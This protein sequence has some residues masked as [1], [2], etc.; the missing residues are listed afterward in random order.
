MPC[1]IYLL[2]DIAY[3]YMLW[4]H[5][6]MMAMN[7]TFVCF[8]TCVL[9][10]RDKNYSQNKKEIVEDIYL[11]RV[12][13]NVTMNYASIHATVNTKVRCGGMY[14]DILW[15]RKIGP[16]EIQIISTFCIILLPGSKLFYYNCIFLLFITAVS[17]YNPILINILFRFLLLKT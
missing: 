9:C 1:F 2:D 12:W 6:M 8:V 3:T 5:D 4:C 7:G 16:Y 15:E 10:R 17:V 14:I 13:P 11:K